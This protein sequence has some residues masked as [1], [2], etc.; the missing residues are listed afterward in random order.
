MKTRGIRRA[1]PDSCGAVINEGELYVYYGGADAVTCVA[2][3]NLDTFLYEL[4]TYGAPRLG[5]ERRPS[6][7]R[8]NGRS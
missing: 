7:T 5:A 1:S 8:T 4:K 2:M 3:A 6:T